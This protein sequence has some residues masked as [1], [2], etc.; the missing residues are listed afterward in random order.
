[1]HLFRRLT[2]D[3]DL[4]PR[5]FPLFRLAVGQPQP[6]RIDVGLNVLVLFQ[7]LFLTSRWIVR[8]IFPA[9]SDTYGRA[10]VGNGGPP[11][12]LRESQFRGP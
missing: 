11:L 6:D 2:L 10:L 4:L 3:L 8:F 12:G 9:S 5:F 7:L 1:M